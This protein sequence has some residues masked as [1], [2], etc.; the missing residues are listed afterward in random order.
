MLAQSSRLCNEKATPSGRGCDATDARRYRMQDAA[1]D[2]K[3]FTGRGST[4]GWTC[5]PRGQTWQCRNRG[6]Q[7][8][9]LRCH[10][11]QS[12]V[13]QAH[14]DPRLDCPDEVGP[15]GPP[16]PASERSS[17][18]LLVLSQRST[19]DSRAQICY[20]S[21]LPPSRPASSPSARLAIISA[22]HSHRHLHRR[23]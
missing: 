4:I 8:T 11:S 14:R 9:T 3:S 6:G 23:S 20:E 12:H 13:H 18:V 2:S 19:H 7:S 10:T 16:P 5:S 21:V 22:S 17:D 15:D 1:A